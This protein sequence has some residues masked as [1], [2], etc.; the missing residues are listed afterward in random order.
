MPL[1]VISSD[2][3]RAATTADIVTDLAFPAVTPTRD[4]DWREYRV[5]AW[6]GLTRAEI[7]RQWPGDLER[8]DRGDL[9]APP[10]GEDR[11]HFEARLVRALDRVTTTA[12]EEGT[13]LVVSHGGAIRSLSRRFQAPIDHVGNLAGVLLEGAQGRFHQIGMVD[14]RRRNDQTLPVVD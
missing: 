6:S 7:E 3:Q 14:L 13:A 1:L 8:W 2:L 11:G 10:G 5:G 4:P 12:G 9:R